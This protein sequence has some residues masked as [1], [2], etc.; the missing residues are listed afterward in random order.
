MIQ[1]GHN[2]AYVT[3]AQLSWNV[4]ICGLIGS[5]QSWLLQSEFSQ[6]FVYELINSLW[7]GFQI[8]TLPSWL[9]KFGL[10]LQQCVV[11]RDLGLVMARG[12]S[13]HY[14][15]PWEVTLIW[16]QQ[17]AQKHTLPHFCHTCVCLFTRQYCL[18]VILCRYDDTWT[19]LFH[20]QTGVSM[21]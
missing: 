21:V 14:W 7:N 13:P 16:P 6:E 18:H 11:P 15:C 3:T 2:F 12:T 1:P 17:T 4:Q 10:P 8:L 5:M 20:K 9:A 19:I